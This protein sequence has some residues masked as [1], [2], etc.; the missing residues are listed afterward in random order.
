[1]RIVYIHQY[2]CNPGMAGGIR[3]YEQARRLVARGHTVDVITTDIT[4]TGRCWST[5]GRWAW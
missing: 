4:P 5:P 2:Y 1:M 3:S